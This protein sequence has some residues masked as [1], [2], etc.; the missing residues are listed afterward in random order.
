MDLQ[1]KGS[2][3]VPL[4]GYGTFQL[5]GFDTI[6]KCLDTALQNGYRLIDT[7]AVYKNEEDIGICLKELLPKYSLTRAD[8]F[9]TSKLDPADQG[10]G[11]YEA[12]T[13]SLKRLQLDYL[14]L[15]LIHWPGTKKL[16]ADDP[17]NAEM[18]RESWKALERAHREGKCKQIGISNYLVHHMEEL[19]TYAEVKPAVNQS[20]YHP[21]LLNE[22][23]V[24]WCQKNGIQFQ[25]YTSLGKGEL[26]K[27]PQ[28]VSIAE[29]MQ[30]KPC[31]V[32]LKFAMQDGI[33]VLPM[34]SKPEHIIDNCGVWGWSLSEEDMRTLRSLKIYHRYA[35][36]PTPIV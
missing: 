32:A 15:Y 5:K 11:A 14:D 21:Y 33:G 23:V 36:D 7:A 30:R 34:S 4:F 12:C 8:V 19:F 2:M 20:E 17:K 1:T 16:K 18:R 29:K 26:L 22:D 25:A 9:I 13:E 6:H 3:N 10:P 27:H 24:S 28:L 31:Q 35:W